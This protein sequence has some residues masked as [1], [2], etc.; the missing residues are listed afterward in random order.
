M[1]T[2]IN[3]DLGVTHMGLNM[4]TMN[5]LPKGTVIYAQGKQV[6]SIA[7]IVK[8]K[9]IVYNTGVKMAFG[10]GSFI[11]MGD[12]YTGRHEA[13]CFTLDETVI[14]PLPIKT[15]EELENF[16]EDRQE[17][18]GNMIPALNRY[19][20]EIYKIYRMLRK[21][22]AS[23]YR[24]FKEAYEEI[25]ELA[26]KVGSDINIQ[27]I[28][29]LTEYTEEDLEEEKLMYYIE[30][31]TLP[32]DVQKAYYSHGSRVS[33]YHAEEQIQLISEY[34]EQCVEAA[35]YC[36]DILGKFFSEETEECL[37]KEIAK[38]A[39]AA[40]KKTG[41]IIAYTEKLDA[42]EEQVTELEQ[43]L[44][45]R[46][47]RKVAIAKDKMQ[48]IKNLIT[49]S[50]PAEENDEVSTETAVKY[51]G[52]NTENIESELAGS[53]DKILEYSRLEAEK[54]NSF[55]EMM[56]RF[57]KM[58]DKNDT[59]DDARRLRKKMADIFYQVY[60]KVFLRA[61]EE[62]N[63]PHIIDLFLNYGFMDETLLKKEQLLELYCLQDKNNGEGPCKVYTVKEWLTAIYEG[64]KEPS[65]SEFDMDYAE[66]LR[67]MKKSGQIT[68][69]EMK[70]QLEDP[71]KKLNYEIMNMFR[72]NNRST[73][74]QLSVFVPFLYKDLFMGHLDQS[75][76]TTDII[77][78]LFRQILSV[79]YSVF[80]RE[81]MYQNK[82]KNIEKEM[83]MME[84]FPDVIL[85]PTYGSNGVM[86]QEITG[87]RRTTSG[88]FLLPIFAEGDMEEVLI[89]VM[90]RFRWELC[91]TVQGMAWNDIKVKSLT[92]EYCDYIQ[93]YRKNRDLS[94]EKK[95]KLKLQIQKGRGNTREIFVID[96]VTW[97]KN[98]SKGS[99]RMN[100]VA[101]EILATY[102]PFSK[103]IRQKIGSQ[104]LYEE[105][106]ARY[107]R[108]K[109]KKVKELDLRYRGLENNKVEIV[110]EMQDT[111]AYYRDM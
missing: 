60:E 27:D 31:A 26:Q 70:Q 44:S 65:K 38:A 84:V 35:N 94:E 66:T 99:I 3:N 107:N 52:M 8:G 10:A 6:E 106:M 17:Y 47:A 103:D 108:E 96:Y 87:K 15:V 1:G 85:M 41:N 30:C 61:Y 77:N 69:A 86:W 45:G 54:C 58:P 24:F 95:E 97:I 4:N 32:L 48:S 92:S 62:K 53:L 40:S 12:L 101:R 2:I 43:A 110:K 59:G 79:D 109:M 100:K 9:V 83:V 102:C 33:I 13:T 39:L 89:K 19:I 57:R 82:E 111:M 23:S 29:S 91:R 68:E 81:A 55:K 78:K 88:R 36:S 49:A 64:R 75:F 22:A 80:Y 67:D 71:R 11:G 98:E 37:Y 104:P 42:I 51:A 56:E 63:H 18:R 76:M 105:A 73:S 14:Y 74:G 5:Q 20:V 90:A 21:E 50:E 7:L 28:D 93:F 25:K 72:Y 16:L 34:T 46:T